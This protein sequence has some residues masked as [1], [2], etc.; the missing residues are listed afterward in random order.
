[1]YTGKTNRLCLYAMIQQVQRDLDLK[2][3]CGNLSLYD[4]LNRPVVFERVGIEHEDNIYWIR[5]LHGH[6]TFRVYGNMTLD[7]TYLESRKGALI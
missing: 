1:M 6:N 4:E 5:L 7:I 3:D 2:L